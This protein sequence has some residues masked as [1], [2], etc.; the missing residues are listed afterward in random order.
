MKLN[1]TSNSS[2]NV[3]SE[4]ALNNIKPTTTKLPALADQRPIR[5]EK[6]FEGSTTNANATGN[7]HHST[8]PRSKTKPHPNAAM[9]LKSQLTSPAAFA[10]NARRVTNAIAIKTI[11][12]STKPPKRCWIIG[13]KRDFFSF[14]FFGRDA[15]SMEG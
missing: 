4:T 6:N 8:A 2:Q 9:R 10:N 5:E 12:K 13:L 1:R 14:I 3:H 7:D 11:P 15:C